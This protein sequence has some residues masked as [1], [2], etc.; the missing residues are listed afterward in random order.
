MRRR[1]AVLWC[2][3]L[4]VGMAVVLY[5]CTCVRV[6]RLVH[7]AWEFYKVA[8]CLNLFIEKEGR[9][10]ASLEDLLDSG[11]VRV[12]EDSVYY[13]VTA[14]LGDVY[15]REFP[16]SFASG[17]PGEMTAFSFDKFTIR[18]G[19]DASE[20]AVVDGKLRDRR[21]GETILLLGSSDRDFR[22]VD[23]DRISVML[24]RSILD[25]RADSDAYGNEAAHE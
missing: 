9:F 1:R 15:S 23:Q 3:L 10:P 6:Q 22:L 24:Y 17:E 21:T 11:L 7:T 19:S 13:R 5:S 4:F 8:S 2:V 14:R 16:E 20:A 18:Y 25:H 12:G